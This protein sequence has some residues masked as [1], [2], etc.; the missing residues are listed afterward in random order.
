VFHTSPPWCGNEK[1]MTYSLSWI[2]LD[3]LNHSPETFE[4]LCP[5]RSKAWGNFYQHIL[6]KA[7]NRERYISVLTTKLYTTNVYSF[8]EVVSNLN[9][10]N[11]WT[12]DKEAAYGTWYKSYLKILVKLIYAMFRQWYFN[13]YCT[14]YHTYHP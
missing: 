6:W 8:I 10:I 4:I 12:Y 9:N 2:C 11:S 3:K 13:P 1:M 5:Q 14:I 7:Q